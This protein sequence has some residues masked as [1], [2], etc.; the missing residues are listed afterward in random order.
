MPR[1]SSAC[2]ARV[3]MLSRGFG[4]GPGGVLR[5]CERRKAPSR[6]SALTV[7]RAGDWVVPPGVSLEEA[8]VRFLIAARSCPRQGL[9]QSVPTVRPAVPGALG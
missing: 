7:L 2:V 8:L 3:R 4:A 5:K 9:P 6:L 1:A